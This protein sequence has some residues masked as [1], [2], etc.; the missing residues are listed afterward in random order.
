MVLARFAGGI[1]PLLQHRDIAVRSLDPRRAEARL[2][3]RQ[4]LD[5]VDETVAKIIAKREPT[6]VDDV[7]MLIRHLGVAFRVNALAGA[8]VGYAVGLKHSALIEE[9][10]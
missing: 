5:A 1:G 8:V 4:N 9:L 10:N 7:A 6:S 3:G 2:V